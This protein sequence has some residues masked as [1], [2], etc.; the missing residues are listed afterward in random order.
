[1]DNGKGNVQYE[2]EIEFANTCQFAQ[3]IS[4]KGIDGLIASLAQ[5]NKSNANATAV[6]EK[7][8]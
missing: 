8:S 1:M 3:E 5:R 6:A 4:S 7:K 2:L